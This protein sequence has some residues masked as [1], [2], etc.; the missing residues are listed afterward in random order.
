MPA[1]DHVAIL[2]DPVEASSEQG[3]Q[4]FTFHR[5]KRM[6]PGHEA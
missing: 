3:E 1:G 4:P 5:A 2:L 6:E